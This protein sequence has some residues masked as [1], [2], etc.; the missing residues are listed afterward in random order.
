MIFFGKEQA[1]SENFLMGVIPGEESEWKNRTRY[2]KKL[3]HQSQ[4]FHGFNKF[5]HCLMDLRLFD[6]R[7]ITACSVLL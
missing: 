5:P 2:I 1:L 6:S 3:I 7:K 4:V